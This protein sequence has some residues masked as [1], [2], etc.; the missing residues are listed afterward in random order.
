MV[1]VELCFLSCS[2][3]E[4]KNITLEKVT[5][6]CKCSYDCWDAILKCE[7]TAFAQTY[8]SL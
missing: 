4:D 5:D 1:L 3:V 2:V 6:T 8:E 7:L